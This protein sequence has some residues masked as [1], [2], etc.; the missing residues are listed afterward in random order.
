[1]IDKFIYNHVIYILDK[2]FR[3]IEDGVLEKPEYPYLELKNSQIK[4]IESEIIYHT[5]HNFY[6]SS[7][8]NCHPNIN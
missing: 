3:I 7:S 2:G 4:N 8:G 1:M 6:V 5:S